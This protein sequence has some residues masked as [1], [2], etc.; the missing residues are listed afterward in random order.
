MLREPVMYA[1]APTHRNSVALPKP[2]Q[3]MCSTPPR[4]AGGR[5]ERP[6]RDAEHHVP[7]VGDRRVGEQALEVVLDE[8]VR[9][10]DEHRQR[11]PSPP[12]ASPPRAAPPTAET[13]AARHQVDARLDHRGG[14]QVRADRRRRLH[15]VGQP[16]VERHLRRLGPRGDQQ[17]HEHRA[18]PAAG[19]LRQRARTRTSRSWRTG[20]S[21]RRGR[22]AR[23]RCVITSA[24]NPAREAL[25][26]F[27]RRRSA[28]TSRPSS[29]PRR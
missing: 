12:A 22:T 8:V 28:P 23:R 29:S 13:D 7:E 10:R 4:K 15:R 1:I 14:V 6:E 5:A 2:W 20:R 21:M 17:H 24:L 27:R 19:E 3:R 16:G 11:A 25:L 26:A 9:E 18:A